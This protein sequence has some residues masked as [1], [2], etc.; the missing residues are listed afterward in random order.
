VA[1]FDKLWQDLLARYELQDNKWMKNLYDLREHWAAVTRDSFTADFTST[2]RSE[3]V[4]NVYKKRFH[5][6]L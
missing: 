4:N 2:H 1:Y 6:K 3:G 5:R